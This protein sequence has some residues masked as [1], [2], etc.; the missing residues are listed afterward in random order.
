MANKVIHK[1]SNVANK[2]PSSTEVGIGELAINFADL[3]LY[4]QE[5]GG[6]VIELGK[7]AATIAWNDITSL[8][9]TIAGFGITDSW[10]PPSPNAAG[11]LTN[12]GSGVLTWQA[13]PTPFA[14]P[15]DAVGTLTNDGAGALSWVAATWTQATADTLYL[16]LAGG[17]LTGD[18]T[19]TPLAGIGARNVTM[20]AA[21]KLVASPMLPP[22][23]NFTGAVDPTTGL[24]ATANRGDMVVFNAAGVVNTNPVKSGD[25]AFWDGTKWVTVPTTQDLSAYLFK[26]TP[27]MGVLMSDNALATVT[28]WHPLS[29]FIVPTPAAGV[30]QSITAA[31][32]ADVPLTLSA[33]NTSLVTTG[34]AALGTPTATH[35]LDVS[36]AIASIIKA[37]ETGSPSLSLE[38]SSAELLKVA[39]KTT[40]G[41]TDRTS[42]LY[43]EGDFSIQSN[44]ATGGGNVSVFCS[45]AAHQ[46]VVA[47]ASLLPAA[48]T[49]KLQVN[50]DAFVLGAV[51]ATGDVHAFFS[52]MRLKNVVGPIAAAL[53]SVLSLDGFIYR[54]NDRALSLGAAPS[55]DTRVGV[56]AQAVAAILP[57][58]VSPAPFDQSL[59]EDGNPSSLSGDDYLTVDYS[60]LVPLLIESIK[61]L[62]DKVEALS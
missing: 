42:F 36:G 7:G 62:N 49:A 40:A 5:P 29:E 35:A 25:L 44:T 30:A 41:D 9:T 28:T 43:S 22:A 31:N 32:A 61:E 50:G 12:D 57:E 16:P 23:T 19:I 53:E 27:A 4:T 51:Q 46:V 37:G 18:L 10:L 24:P 3:A 8:P 1:R 34:K 58:A 21:G 38:D 33:G 15:A 52:D 26:P 13:P 45:K 11:H 20:D 59:D 17:T 54:P 39:K 6:T 56:S 2:V 48:T 47:G 14:L 55:D 60:K